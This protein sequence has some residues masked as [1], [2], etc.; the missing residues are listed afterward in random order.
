MEQTNWRVER[1][2]QELVGRPLAVGRRR[3]QQVALLDGWVT[4]SGEAAEGGQFGWMRVAPERVLVQDEDGR[5]ET[6]FL[7]DSTQRTAGALAAAGL[8]LAAL[9]ALAI[10]TAKLIR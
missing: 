1:I 7:R 9:C 5:E 8:V 3:L 6:V 4:R 10:T 2:H